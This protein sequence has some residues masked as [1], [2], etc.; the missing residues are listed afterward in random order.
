MSANRD[1]LL[2]D[3]EPKASDRLYLLLFQGVKA[4]SRAFQNMSMYAPGHPMVRAAVEQAAQSF[5]DVLANRQK[6]VISIT[7]NHFVY[8]DQIISQSSNELHDLALLLHNLDIV[9]IEFHYGLTI[10]E[11]VRFLQALAQARKQKYDGAELAET[12][13]VYSI[14]KICL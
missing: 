7:S 3:A 13:A 8:D 1:N 11:L 4:L 14:D 12:I 9:A 2:D 5:D 10:E 6:L